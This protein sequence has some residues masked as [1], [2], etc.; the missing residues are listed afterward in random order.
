[1]S[2]DFLPL[3][4]RTPACAMRR[5]QEYRLLSCPLDRI[6]LIT[7]VLACCAFPSFFVYRS[8]KHSEWLDRNL[9]TP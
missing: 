8:H 9:V 6:V 1:M 5:A 2:H 3:L 4:L 7:I